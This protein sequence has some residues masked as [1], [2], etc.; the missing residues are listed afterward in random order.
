[1]PTIQIKPRVKKF[2]MALPPKH[3]RQIKDY[4]LNLVKHY[5]HCSDVQALK[6]YFPYLR[7]DIGEYR[8]IFRFDKKETV[9]TVIMIG[10]RNDSAVYKRVRRIL[11]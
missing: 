7:G 9:I 2:M 4:L 6:G 8:V 5:P 1:M 3:R 11:L 10:E